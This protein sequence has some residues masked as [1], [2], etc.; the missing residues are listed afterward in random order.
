[1]RK[2]EDDVSTTAK[3]ISSVVVIGGPDSGKSNYIFRLWLAINDANGAI[4]ADGLPDHLD[5]LQTGSQSLLRGEF[6]QKTPHDVFA[7]NVIPFKMDQVGVSRSGKLIVPD[8]YGERWISI[9]KKREW[10]KEWEERI[11]EPCGFLI[12]VRASSD[13][14]VTPL[15]WVQCEKLWGAP[16]GDG[17]VTDTVMPT[18]I[19]ITDWLQ[20][21]RRAFNDRIGGEFRPRVGLV[22]AAWDRVPQDRQ[23][24]GP[25]AYIAREFP[26]LAQFVQSNDDSYDFAAFGVS[27]AGGDFVH[28]P[29]FKE[30]SLNQLDPLSEGYAV[31][32]LDGGSVK[33]PDL[34]LPIAWVM[35]FREKVGG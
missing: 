9:Y 10:T 35:G 34:T 13:Q 1:L 2:S 30:K 19:V 16:I 28:E 6:A 7:E 4:R 29:G 11:A 18:Q 20:F 27:V 3:P 8:C 32:E 22:V 31:H 17:E 25:S 26:L 5:Y 14:I 33:D 12:F 23:A 21:I 15:D 24:E